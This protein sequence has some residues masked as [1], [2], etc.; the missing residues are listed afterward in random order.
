[1][2]IPRNWREMPTNVSFTGK[3]KNF[4]DSKLVYF[5]YPG[6]EIL[7]NGTYDQVKERFLRKGFSVK[8]TEGILLS[9]LGGVA[10]ETPIPAG[11][12][13]EG[14]HKFVRSEVWK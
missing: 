6:G 13:L 11:I 5:K 9:F 12:V 8:V 14:L 3:E 7:L 4:D 2:E 1:M 10:T